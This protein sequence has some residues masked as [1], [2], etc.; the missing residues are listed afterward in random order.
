[1]AR[2]LRIEF[3]G[4]LYHVTSRG[5]AGQDAFFSDTDR[6]R[7]M[8]VFGDIVERFRWMCH[9][10][11]LM[12]NHYHLLIETPSANL[13]RGMRHLNGVYTQSFNR[14]HKRSGH[15]F[16][17]RFKSRLVEKESHLLEVARYVVLN[18]VRVGMVNHPR[19]WMWSSYSATCGEVAT[20][21]FLSVDWLL[22]QFHTRR[23][24]AILEYCRFVKDGVHVRLWEDLVGGI[25]LG[26][27]S[28]CERLKPLLTDTELS[29]E[30]PRIERTWAQPTLQELF[31]DVGNDKPTRNACI[32]EAI[33]RHGYTLKQVGEYLG[34]HYASVSRIAR[35]LDDA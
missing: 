29:K 5:N 1:M 7:F 31:K 12:S 30:I 35:I 17:G 2:P 15:V 19:Q 3:E 11:C 9:A 28:F 18:P 34:L 33:R 21:E 14:K 27:D 6:V 13:S 25:L 23:K 32:H 8:D 10:Y 4:A 22:S 16:Q 26:S 20:P 24:Q